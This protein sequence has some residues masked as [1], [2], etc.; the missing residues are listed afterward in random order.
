MKSAC[1]F[2]ACLFIATAE[3]MGVMRKLSENKL[4]P[5]AGLPSCV[6]MAVESGDQTKGSSIIIFKGTSG[7]LIPWHWQTPTEHL[8]IVSGSAKVE[9]KDGAS[10]ILGP[11]LRNDAEQACAPIHLQFGLFRFRQF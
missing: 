3:D 10:S 9:M 4:A 8:L 1:L 2:V 5:I 6:S 11:G 7:C